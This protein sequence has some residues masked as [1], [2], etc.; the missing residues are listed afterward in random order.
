MK[1]ALLALFAATQVAFSYGFTY[2]FPTDNDLFLDVEFTYPEMQTADIPSVVATD[3][4]Y[5]IASEGLHDESGIK[6]EPYVNWVKKHARTD[7][8]YHFR[9]LHLAKKDKNRFKLFQKKLKELSKK[10]ANKVDVKKA[11]KHFNKM[12]N[13]MGKQ[14]KQA[15]EFFKQY[16]DSLESMDGQ[17]LKEYIASSASLENAK[18]RCMISPSSLA[19]FQQNMHPKTYFAASE[20][21]YKLDLNEVDRA[22]I[23]EIIHTMGT[24]GLFSLLKKKSHLEA[25]GDKINHVPPLQLLGYV[26]T[27]PTLKKDMKA[28]SGNTFKW[29]N[30]IDGL[31][32]TMKRDWNRGA[33]QPQ[34]PGFAAF[35]G[36]DVNHLRACLEK[37][38]VDK[39][40]KDLL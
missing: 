10:G 15:K 14:T 39:M 17:S 23:Y 38:K 7:D 34:L 11:K 30:F 6:L 12:L 28:I 9:I 40:V 8:E 29:S 21:G 1:R 33:L 25:L 32:R 5:M 22:N 27:D 2:H 4:M 18:A 20:I 31:A 3:M 19:Y 16:Q 13:E 35:V 24:H 26:L 36:A 37:G